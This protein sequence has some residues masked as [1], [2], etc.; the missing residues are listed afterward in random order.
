MNFIIFL[1]PPVLTL[2][3]SIKK[4][5]IFK[6]DQLTVT[7]NIKRQNGEQIIKQS[8]I[9]DDS[10]YNGTVLTRSIYKPGILVCKVT[11]QAGTSTK[12]VTLTTKG[13]ICC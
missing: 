2:Q 3:P 6:G 8:W 4:I 12:R 11:N 10:V 1:G 13:K 9:H 5:S 7:C